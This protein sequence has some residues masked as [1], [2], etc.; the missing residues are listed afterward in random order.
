MEIKTYNQLKGTE[1]TEALKH[2]KS[3]QDARKQV[4]K[5]ARHMSDS[6]K[7]EILKEVR[8]SVE[9]YANYINKRQRIFWAVHGGRIVGLL[10]SDRKP[11]KL[12]FDFMQ[13]KP[14]TGVMKT[15]G[16]TVGEHLVEAGMDF[17]EKHGLEI[18]KPVIL[19]REENFLAALFRDTYSQKDCEGN[20]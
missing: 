14:S 7:A 4:W 13:T 16:K 20:E 3:W 6:S 12:G 18:T 10:K 19:P 15:A 2:Y 5:I 1:R 17:A 9:E 11:G 8:M